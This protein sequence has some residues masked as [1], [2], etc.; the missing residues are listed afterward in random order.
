MSLY[1][2]SAQLPPQKKDGIRICIMRRPGDEIQWDI[3]IPHLAPSHQLLTDYHQ[4]KVDWDG[5][6]VQFQ[7]EVIKDK[8]EYLQV[9]IDL[10]KL[11][12][13]T[14][15]CWEETPERCHR[16]LIAEECKKINT[17]LEVVIK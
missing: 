1:T 3:W 14:L 4:G 16:R 2:K 13:I 9:V 15:I 8:K 12:D 10:A 5:F 17:S 6:C 11:H 7:K